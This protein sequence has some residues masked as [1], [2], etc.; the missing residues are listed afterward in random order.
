M[1]GFLSQNGKNLIEGEVL[2]H[3]ALKSKGKI[4]EIGSWKGKS[5][6]WLAKGSEAGSR[7]KVY[8]IDP[9]TG[10]EEERG[11]GKAVWTFDA[12]QQNISHADVA[13]Y[14]VPIIKT[15]LEGIYDVPGRIGLVFIDGATDYESVKKDFE[16]WIP[17]IAVGGIVAFHDSFGIGG[18]GVRELVHNEVFKSPFFKNVCYIN[19]ITYAEKAEQTTLL[20]RFK[21]RISL[22]VK[23]VHEQSLDYPQPFRSLAKKLIWRPFYNRWVKELKEDKN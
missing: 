10:S 18:A 15:S 23:I 4:V 6:I 8:A 22:F 7:Q 5:T 19:N 20:D 11:D 1:E 12:F 2:Y 14:V 3:L 9:H 13:K 17:K 16:A 21:N